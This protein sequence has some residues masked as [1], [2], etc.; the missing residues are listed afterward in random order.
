[1]MRKLLLLELPIG[2]LIAFGQKPASKPAFAKAS[3]DKVKVMVMDIKARLTL[4]CC[5]M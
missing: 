1:M 2:N 4:A 5:A 3:V